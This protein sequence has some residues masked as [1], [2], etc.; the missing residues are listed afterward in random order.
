MNPEKY[1]KSDEDFIDV[2]EA[3]TI[4]AARALLKACEIK[5]DELR[6]VNENKPKDSPD[7]FTKDFRFVA[8]GIHICNWLLG[9]PEETR[10]YRERLAERKDGK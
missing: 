5:R 9:L 6:H 10:K 1:I 4:R 3:G 2:S 7:D 8:G